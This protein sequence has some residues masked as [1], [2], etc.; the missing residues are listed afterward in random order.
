[1]GSKQFADCRF[2]A[3]RHTDQH[4]IFLLPLQSVHHFGNGR[5]INGTIQFYR[6]RMLNGIRY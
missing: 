3:A 6:K 5:G 2:T 4:D 1:M